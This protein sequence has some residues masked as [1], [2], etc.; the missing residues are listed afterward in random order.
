MSLIAT[1]KDAGPALQGFLASLS[2]QRRKPDEIV[3]V[4]GGSTDGTLEALMA[5]E[6]MR[7]IPAPGSNISRGRNLAIRATSHE[8]IAVTDADCVLDPGWLEELLKPIEAGADVAAGFY[9]PLSSSFFQT[10]AAAVSVPE[11]DEIRTGW[12]PSARSIAFRRG[13]FEAAG[14]YPEWLPVGE[15]MYLNHRLVEVGA[16][17]ELAPSAVVHWPVRPTLA[18]T[19][20]QYA[21]YA[22]GDALAGMYPRRHLVRFGTYTTGAIVVRSGKPWLIALG[23]LAAAGYAS[24]PLQRAWRRLPASG[25]RLAGTVAVP[26]L[27]AFV[28]GAKM[29]GFVRGLAVR[30]GRRN[31]ELAEI[32]APRRSP[33]TDGRTSSTPAA[34]GRA[35]P[36]RPPRAGPR[37]T[38]D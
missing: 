2:A 25:Q 21:R 9:R 17:I 6:G 35:T 20:R 24:R 30:A 11:P 36:P 33:R 27:M 22:E 3:V 32:R 5:A 16:R 26:A 38:R 23:C 15:D 8:V 7:V 29:W 34:S 14:G 28:D 4:D 31:R 12:L 13:I 1:V 37:A 18:A 10:C 19:W